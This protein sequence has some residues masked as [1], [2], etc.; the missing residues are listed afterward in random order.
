M[1]WQYQLSLAKQRTKQDPHLSLAE[2]L[3]PY[4]HSYHGRR[5]LCDCELPPSAFSGRRV[6]DVGC[7]PWPNLLVFDNCERYGID[8]LMDEYRAMGWPLDEWT[9]QTGYQY[10]CA[11]AE[12]MPFE[13]GFFTG[14]ISLNAIDHVDDFAH[15]A[16]EIRRVLV[17]DGLFCMHVHYH[18]P[19]LTEPITITDELF[20]EHFGWVVGLQHRDYDR[21]DC[22]QSPLSSEPNDNRFV[23]WSN[24]HG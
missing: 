4:L 22:G 5:Y 10:V 11:P 16:S 7:G 8:P 13:D 21:K 2:Q 15:V 14:I 20:M 9:E 6:L 12:A 24:V 19:R 1:C 17:R 23:V 18:E 3:N